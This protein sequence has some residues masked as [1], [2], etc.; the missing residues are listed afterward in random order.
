[1]PFGFVFAAL[2]YGLLC[3]GLGL[4]ALLE[5]GRRVAGACLALLGVSLAIALLRRLGWARWTGR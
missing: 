5:P 4:A 3:A 1:M 2:Y